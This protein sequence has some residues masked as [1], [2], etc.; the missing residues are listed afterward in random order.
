MLVH[1][2]FPVM[3]RTWWFPT[4]YMILLLLTPLLNIALRNMAQH[5]HLYC[6]VVLFC[7][8][9][10]ADVLLYD[11][12]PYAKVLWFVFL[13]VL[14]AYLRNYDI[15]IW[16]KPR[17][18]GI[19]FIVFYCAICASMLLLEPNKGE[20]FFLKALF[21]AFS[22]QMAA[23]ALLICAVSLFLAFARSKPFTSR[24]VNRAAAG[25]FGV[26]L[27][28]EHPALRH[29][30]W[31]DLINAG[32]FA[33]ARWYGLYAFAACVAVFLLCLCVEQIRISFARLPGTLLAKK[34]EKL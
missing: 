31:D 25:T 29:W 11:E 8:S 21:L 26:Y 13:Y 32:R 22:K 5:V 33:F 14:A 15:P 9:A 2:F 1:T 16:K 12:Q 18:G 19:T 4:T 23:P 28:H 7:I 30:I 17:N 6:V 34:R 10:L 3:L 20:N 24:F 27:I